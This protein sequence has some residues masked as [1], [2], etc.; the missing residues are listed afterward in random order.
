MSRKNDVGLNTLRAAA[1]GWLMENG[2]KFPE[3]LY[4]DCV[5]NRFE[6]T[7]TDPHDDYNVK[8]NREEL[9]EFAFKI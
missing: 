4:F 8:F 6:K 5:S 2:Y 1:R 3:E 7:P 9:E